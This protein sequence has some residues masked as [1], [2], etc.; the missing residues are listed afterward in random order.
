M[1]TPKQDLLSALKGAVRDL[2]EFSRVVREHTLGRVIVRA[3]TDTG[4]VVATCVIAQRLVPQ[5]GAQL[6]LEDAGATASVAAPVEAASAEVAHADDSDDRINGLAIGDII[7]VRSKSGVDDD[8]FCWRTTE[9]KNPRDRDEGDT[10]WAEIE[11]VEGKAWR[12]KVV[13]K[14]TTK[15]LG[16]FAITATPDETAEEIEP[17]PAESAEPSTRVETMADV[18]AILARDDTRAAERETG[19]A[20]PSS[21]SSPITAPLRQRAIILRDSG[22]WSRARKGLAA[23]DAIKT[24]GAGSQSGGSCQPLVIIYTPAVNSPDVM[25]LLQRLAKEKRSFLD[26]GEVDRAVL[27]DHAPSNR[28]IRKRWNA[29]HPDMQVDVNQWAPMDSV[30]EKVATTPDAPAKPEKKARA[31]KVEHTA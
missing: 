30:L 12:E 13:D 7:S 22:D 5:K 9:E 11:H 4:T 17:D 8:G 14:P 15:A 3:E 10:L 27:F 25:T 20:E 23:W 19:S 1:S 2:P 18:E 24:P 16:A 29:A 6:A 31:K 28:E 26:L 21:P